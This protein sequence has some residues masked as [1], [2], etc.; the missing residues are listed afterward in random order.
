MKNPIAK[1]KIKNGAT[2]TMELY[3]DQAPESVKN[4]I[5]L[6]NKNFYE[7]LYFW[8]VEPH[9]MIQSGCPD[10]DGTGAM[11]YCIKSECIN[12]GVNNTLKFTR[13]AVGLG[14]FEYNTECSDFYIVLEDNPKLDDEYVCFARVIDGMEEADRIGSFP[15]EEC[16]F[17]HKALEK[18]YIESLTV[19]TFVVDYGEP[20]KLPGFPKE[21]LVA[22]MNAAIEERQKS[23]YSAF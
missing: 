12:N 23:G 14:R 22:R 8:R 2:I 4:F 15:V 6:C 11:E 1:L 5:S 9:K 16:G 17:M 18:A 19:D 10:N 20:E 21:E 13:G 3:P 7:G